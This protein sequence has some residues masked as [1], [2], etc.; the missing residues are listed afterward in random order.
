M[1]SPSSTW[2][3][4][5]RVRRSARAVGLRQVDGATDGRRARVDNEPADPDRRPPV[6]TMSSRATAT[7]RWS[8]RTTRSI[9]TWTSTTTSA[10]VSGCAVCRSPNASARSSAAPAC[11]GSPTPRAQAEPA[12][13]RATSAR[14]HGSRNRAR[15]AGV[16]D[17]RAALEPRRA[18][19][20]PDANARSSESSASSGHDD[21]R[22]ARPGRG[23]DAWPTGSR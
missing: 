5:R 6:S 18:T 17:G 1:P 23:D 15:A 11:S 2:G 20:R 4:G 21:L 22:D 3:R 13:R 10:S 16:P 7:S 12:V 14:R 19:P 9:R 8:S